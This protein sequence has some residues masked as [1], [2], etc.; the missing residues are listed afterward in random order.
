MQYL[1]LHYV[2]G[3]VPARRF[4]E[5]AEILRFMNELVDWHGLRGL[6]RLGCRA[7]SCSWLNAER[8]WSVRFE[9]PGRPAL[10]VRSKYVA[11]ANG[12]LSVPN[13]TSLPGLASFRGRAFHSAE[14]DRSVE[15]RGKT[16]AVV[17]TGASAIQIVPAVAQ[18][19]ARV[20]VLQRTP[21][22][23]FP[24]NDGP[25]GADEV[26]ALTGRDQAAIAAMRGTFNEFADN[27]VFD[28]YNDPA[29]NAQAA[30]SHHKHLR[31][32]VRDPGVAAAL[33]PQYPQGCR[34]AL[35]SD[36]YHV[37]FNRDNVRLVASAVKRVVADGVET[38]AGEQVHGVDV[39]VMCTGFHT[40]PVTDVS[41]VGRGGRERAA[42]YRER[43]L[44]TYLGL[45]SRGFPN[46]FT[47]LGPQSWTPQGNTSEAID[48]QT[49]WVAHVVAGM[50]ACGALELEPT[51]GAELYWSEL[52]TANGDRSVVQSCSNTWYTDANGKAIMF[53]GRWYSF[54]KEL[55][56]LDP[57]SRFEL[58]GPRGALMD[59]TDA[60][61]G[62]LASDSQ[63]PT[64]YR[65][66]AGAA[67]AAA[68]VV[69]P[70]PARL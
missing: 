40:G 46:L 70:A 19:A 16:V 24:R 56:E 44:H 57:T 14:W 43:G 32:Q 11:L 34:R 67:A 18:L 63:L 69:A 3:F 10:V 61:G 9:R 2:P 5:Q 47:L 64:A 20:I 60:L 8:Q 28:T 52:C 35:L 38:E 58:R 27:F 50:E 45:L 37:A 29:R 59:A 7:V 17:G 36:D 26:A 48:V 31:R 23:V 39:L 62:F 25:L 13:T 6:L 65:A 22:F 51:A 4:S 66:G 30:R 41:I 53:T 12:P 21:A 15:L 49:N 54:V 1:P 68:A 55:V 33:T 42:S